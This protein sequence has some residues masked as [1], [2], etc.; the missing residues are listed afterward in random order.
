MRVYAEY[1]EEE[2]LTFRKN[3]LLQFG[4]CWNLIGNAVLSNPGSARP[5]NR[6]SHDLLVLISKFYKQYRERGDFKSDNWFEFSPDSTMRFVEKIFNGWYIGKRIELNGVIQLFNTFNIR[7]QYLSKAIGK[8]GVNS[9]LLFS[10]NVYKYFQ[11][12][13]TY[14]GFGNEVLNEDVLRNVAEHIFN[15]SS[16]AVLSPYHK[17]FSRNSFYHPMYVNRAHEQRYFQ[18]YKKEVLA[19]IV[20]NA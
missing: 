9:N 18:E 20:E 3:T 4:N 5:I 14:F 10:Y 7:D 12:R 19:A 2:G 8:I 11:D 13:P 6:V 17:E 1:F 15:K 16:E